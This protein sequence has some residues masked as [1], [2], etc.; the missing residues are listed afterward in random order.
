MRKKGLSLPINTVIIII[1]AFLVLVAVLLFFTGTFSPAANTTKAESELRSE[2]W[3][4][5]RS[6]YTDPLD[7][8][9]YPN[10]N[11]SFDNATE[12]KSYCTGME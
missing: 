3:E 8:A 6:L 2:C 9:D 5:Q 10:L 11:T 12:A 4:W 1:V 7:Y